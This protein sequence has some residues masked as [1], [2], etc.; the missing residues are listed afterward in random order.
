MNDKYINFFTDFGF[1]RLF[2]SEPSKEL[3]IDFLNSLLE[4]YE[5]PIVNLTYKNTENLGSTELDRKA[6]FD[7]YCETDTGEKIIVE[8]QKASQKF[9]KDRSVFYSTFP[10]QEQAKKGDWNY[11]LK[12]VYTI[13]ILNFV[14]DEDK[15]D[16]EKYLYRVK[17]SDIETNKVFYDKLSFIYLEMPKFTKDLDQ[18]QTHFEKWMYAL[19]NVSQLEDVPEQLQEQIFEKFFNLARIAKL[20]GEER[21][22]YQKS[23]KYYRDMHNVIDT[24]QEKGWMKGR[25]QGLE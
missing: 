5:A 24:A 18:L 13:G 11:E 1:K 17:L 14:F 25:E 22:S 19:Q 15:D 7:L 4:G 16:L 9:F 21:E 3:L 12:A 6:V 8:M 23:L 10:I 20:N 2:G